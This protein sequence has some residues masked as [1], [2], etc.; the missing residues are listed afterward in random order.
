MGTHDLKA[1]GKLSIPILPVLKL[2]FTGNY[3]FLSGR[4]DTTDVNWL[5]AESA[6]ELLN[7]IYPNPEFCDTGEE[8]SDALIVC[9]DSLLFVESKGATF[10]ADAKYGTDPAKL[11]DEIETKLVQNRESGKEDK[12]RLRPCPRHR[13]AT[14]ATEKGAA[15]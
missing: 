6:D 10:T 14:A 7:H 1:G 4:D 9:G 13:Q 3:T 11:R 15:K 8:V 12:Q 5:I 2:G